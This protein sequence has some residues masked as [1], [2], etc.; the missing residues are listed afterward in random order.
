MKAKR[1]LA[2]LLTMV[3]LL[4]LMPTTMFP[5][6]AA[7]DTPNE[8]VVEE[9]YPKN[10]EYDFTIPGSTISF[11]DKDGVLMTE[12]KAW[13]DSEA[14]V[15]AWYI[16]M[17]RTTKSDLKLGYSPEGKLFLPHRVYE[18]DTADLLYVKDNT[19]FR[20]TATKDAEQIF[21]GSQI[22]KTVFLN[23]ANGT[24]TLANAPVYAETPFGFVF[25]G[26]TDENGSFS[27]N[28]TTGEFTLWISSNAGYILNKTVTVTDTTDEISFADEIN[29][30]VE[31]DITARSET[32]SKAS[33]Y[34]VALGK[35]NEAEAKNMIT[36]SYVSPENK[37]FVTP[38]AYSV[39]CGIWVEDKNPNYSTATSGGL[40]IDLNKNATVNQNTAYSFSL[41]DFEVKFGI[42]DAYKQDSYGIDDRIA[43][44]LNAEHPDGYVMSARANRS[45]DQDALVVT[46]GE[47]QYPYTFCQ[48]SFSVFS[49]GIKVYKNG[50]ESNP[51]YHGDI[52]LNESG[53]TL[54]LFGETENE[55]IVKCFSEW[56]SMSFPW[57]FPDGVWYTTSFKTQSIAGIYKTFES[58]TDFSLFY[59][60]ENGVM[61]EA[62]YDYRDGKRFYYISASVQNGDYLLAA[63]WSYDWMKYNIITVSDELFANGYQFVDQT[64]L[65]QVEIVVANGENDEADYDTTFDLIIE[66]GNRQFKIC[67]SQPGLQ[68]P[69]GEYVF[70]V[71]ATSYRY[72]DEYHILDENVVL[73]TEKRTVSEASC[74]INVDY[75]TYQSFTVEAG[76]YVDRDYEGNYRKHF[77][78][79][80][81][82]GS[83]KNVGWPD[84]PATLYCSTMPQYATGEMYYYAWQEMVPFS[85]YLLL[86][87]FDIEEGKTYQFD[88]NPAAIE[89]TDAATFGSNENIV[90]TYKVTDGC[91]NV[92]TDIW[93]LLNP[94]GVHNPLTAKAYPFRDENGNPVDNQYTVDVYFRVKGESEYRKMSFT[95][96]SK[97]D[98]GKLEAG[99]Y[100]GYLEINFDTY[101]DEYV[102]EYPMEKGVYED[103][104]WGDFNSVYDNVSRVL[105]GV[106]H[107][108]F[109][110]T[111]VDQTHTCDFGDWVDD[112][113]TDTHTRTC[114]DP[115]CGKS[116][117][118]AH[119]WDEGVQNGTPTCTEGASV[120]YTCTG[121]DKT[122]TE[123]VDHLGHDWSEWTDDGEN[124]PTDTHSRTCQRD[125][126]D[127]AESESHGWS[128]WV[129]IDDKTHKKS[130]FVCEGTR[131]AAHNIDAG[132]V[133]KE[134][135]HLETGVKTFTC[136]DLCGYYY[137]EDIP[138]TA[139]HQWGEWLNNNN[140]GTHSR[141][142]R[143]GASETKDCTYNAG[144]VTKEATHFEEGEKIYTCNECGGIKTETIPKI[145][146]H[147]WGEWLNNNN[148]GTHSRYCRCGA[149]ETKDCT[150]NAGVV[151]KEA[152][153]YEEGEKLYTCTDCGGTK[154][155]TIAKTT[156]HEWTEWHDNGDGT[157]TRAC[158]CNAT[159]TKDCTYDD[160]VVT[161]EP[162]YEATGT[163]TYTCSVCGGKKT[164]TL[165]MLVKTDEIVSPDNSKIKITAPEGSDAVLNENTVL[166]VE[167][168]KDEIAEDVK[169]NVQVVAGNDNAEILVS[170]DISLLLDGATVQPGGKVEVTLPAPE[171]AGDFDTLQ[172]VYIDDEGN[173]TPCETRVNADGTVTF[174]TDHFSRYAIVGVRN[175]S[176]V[177]WILISAIGVALIAG[178]VVAVL[179]IKKK[180][181]IA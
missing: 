11:L 170:Y 181:S 53:L 34:M 86:E 179:V 149:T 113:V 104:S 152:T 148:N 43:F 49:S 137:T 45:Y 5:V 62:V 4:G 158:R 168:V 10:A 138:K 98:L 65:S 69:Y 155:E 157:H 166:K 151:T 146:E 143:C 63:S 19:M 109:A 159:E 165:D 60:D 156:E 58:D 13:S 101:L 124:A 140:N 37:V 35:P 150:Y 93:N 177:V 141:Y 80:Y 83:V 1:F 139:E 92:L 57:L 55:Y 169:A 129:K 26:I 59:F 153:H 171:N 50:D 85:P 130:C 87:P 8:E 79:H 14:V 161:T 72:D 105:H 94:G 135:T 47:N 175:S 17:Y 74:T 9:E 20:V 96:F 32:Y 40:W 110:F 71:Y 97:A 33:G 174:V 100:E 121:C 111:V 144:V 39:A 31:I 136:T 133:T 162:T 114:K 3:M 6:S 22:L 120:T 95:N 103:E 41:A 89:I 112:V 42:Q 106:L 116:E 123:D 176:P 88:F 180:K 172:V 167:E 30:A 29:N 64:N 82:D 48:D 160:G 75:S 16:F 117:T 54:S 142:C 73:H 81:A 90:L 132:V 84:A 115:E 164:E 52:G 67:G 25:M 118:E 56:D 21:D 178:A 127:A 76:M 122:K 145:A 102:V 70:D 107:N 119:T 126:C 44:R 36:T 134:A 125:G 91:G 77:V 68:I 24:I 147:Q 51:V 173:V 108:D 2:L 27:L 15:Y 163:K 7:E 61:S 154:T 66:A 128:R 18:G 131:T 99:E 23:A 38:G 46:V 12:E 28:A 78:L